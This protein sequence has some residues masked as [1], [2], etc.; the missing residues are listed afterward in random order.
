MWSAVHWHL[1]SAAATCPA[2][3]K[4]ELETQQTPVPGWVIRHAKHIKKTG[5]EWAEMY[6]SD[7]EVQ[8]GARDRKN[9][10]RVILFGEMFLRS[11]CVCKDDWRMFPQINWGSGH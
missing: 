6:G 5:A 1:L 9:E 7:G 10:Y 8:L 4:I 11:K 2:A 3:S